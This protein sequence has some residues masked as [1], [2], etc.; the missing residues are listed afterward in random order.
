MTSAVSGFTKAQ[1]PFKPGVDGFMVY[2]VVW[3]KE[4]GKVAEGLRKSYIHN[5]ENRHKQVGVFFIFVG[6]CYSV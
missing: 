6:S 5:H 2:T 3:N 1:A 4:E